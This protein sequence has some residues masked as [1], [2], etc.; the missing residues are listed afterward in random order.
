MEKNCYSN[1]FDPFTFALLFKTFIRPVLHYGIECLALN[2][3]E[4]NDM[5][6]EENQLLKRA[7]GL[8]YYS[9]TN[10][11]FK[12]LK[13]TDF[14]TRYKQ[15]TLSFAV[16]FLN[17]PYCNL[18][19]KAISK[20]K[21]DKLP[22]RSFIRRIITL[23][24]GYTDWPSLQLQ[25]FIKSKHIKNKRIQDLNDPDVRLLYQLLLDY[26]QNYTLIDKLLNPILVDAD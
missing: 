22:K 17:N 15:I 21:L 9:S 6:F 7:L 1:G 19:V 3:R 23:N 12:F 13:I 20:T 8:Q 10:T 16:R 25:S 5:V 2:T 26:K 18:F 24:P 14:E 4:V 11:L